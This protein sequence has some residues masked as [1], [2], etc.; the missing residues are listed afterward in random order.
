MTLD[1]KLLSQELN[2][3]LWDSGETVSTAES[4]TAGRISSAITSVP[5]SSEYYKGGVVCYA[6]EVKTA[7]L[8]VSEDVIAEKSPVS[9]EVVLQMVDG[10]LRVFGTT[11]AIAITGFAGPSADASAMG[12]TM[13]VGTIWIGVGNGQETVTCKLT[14]DNGR[15]CNLQNGTREALRMI[16]NFI[17]THRA[18]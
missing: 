4:C 6:N 1:I 3:L 8:G 15:E 13:I 7:L 11:Y 17:R 12:A 14:E 5:G 2:S 18:E 9:E 16:N 10:A